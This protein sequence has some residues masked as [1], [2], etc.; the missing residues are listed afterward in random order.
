MR[1]GLTINAG[2]G[3]LVWTIVSL[4]VAIFGCFIVYYLFVTN[5]KFKTDNKLLAWLK[6]FLNFD[7]MLI[8]TILKITYIFFVIFITLFSFTLIRLSFLSFL[9]FL[10][11]GNVIMRIIYELILITIMIWKNTAEIKNKLK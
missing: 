6:S 1:L 7:K 11:F 8:E 10:V 9:I 4:V 5:K 2:V 3:S